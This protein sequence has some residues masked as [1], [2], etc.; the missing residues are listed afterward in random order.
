[1][2][3]ID[4]GFIWFVIGAILLMG[5]SSCIQNNNFTIQVGSGNENTANTKQVNDSTL[6][7]N[8]LDF[9]VPIGY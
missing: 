6:N 2:Q 4:G 8:S 5:T 1:M 9:D 7:G 3:E